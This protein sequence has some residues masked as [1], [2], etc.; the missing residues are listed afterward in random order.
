[1][2]YA[3]KYGYTAWKNNREVESNQGFK[4]FVFRY[5]E[6]MVYFGIHVQTSHLRRVYES[7]HT[8]NLVITRASTKEVLVE[9]THKG[10]YGF[11]AT[12]KRGG[13]FFPFT[14]A[15]AALLRRQE[16]RDYP[17]RRRSVNVI[18]ESNLD[19]R[20]AYRSSLRSLGLYEDWTTQPICSTNG[21]YGGGHISVDVTTSAT[22]IKSLS[23]KNVAVILGTVRNAKFFRSTGI[24]RIIRFQSYVISYASCMFTLADIFGGQSRNGVFYTDSYGKTLR[25]GPGR[26]HIRQYIKPGFRLEINGKFH[27]QEPWLG[28]HGKDDGGFMVDLGF[29][30]DPS[31]N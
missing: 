30:I 1:M 4:N 11:I 10:D 3:P 19:Y 24:Q 14:V 20:F 21:M 15:D 28:V 2:G 8:I 25:N 6:F 7:H 9:I 13:G 23:Q 5:G 27:V 26:N 29:G 22:G 16:S 12:R 17:S 31:K 18:D